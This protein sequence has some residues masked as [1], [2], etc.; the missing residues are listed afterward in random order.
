MPYSWHEKHVSLVPYSWHSNMYHWCCIP[1]MR[2]VYHGCLIPD[3]R[4]MY[5]WCLVP[6]LGK[7][8]TEDMLLTLGTCITDALLQTWGHVSMMSCPWGTALENYIFINMC[9]LVGTAWHIM[10]LYVQWL[11]ILISI[12]V[13]LCRSYF[14]KINFFCDFYIT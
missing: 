6:D 4:N 7:C 10:V 12:Q 2:N 3:M 11:I 5:N 13:Y 1:D 9:H 8:I 14:M